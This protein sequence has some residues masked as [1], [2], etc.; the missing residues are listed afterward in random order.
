MSCILSLLV[1]I[2]PKNYDNISQNLKKE[3]TKEK[4]LLNALE[5]TK[6]DIILYH[7]DNSMR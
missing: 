1:Q 4:Y 2:L 7:L 3:N 6:N 5:N